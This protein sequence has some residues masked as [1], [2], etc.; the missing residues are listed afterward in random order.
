MPIT[1]FKPGA[2]FGFV[3]DGV[4]NLEL[5][6][7]DYLPIL[8][9]T[10]E[11]QQQTL[12]PTLIGEPSIWSGSFMDITV[13]DVPPAFGVGSTADFNFMVYQPSVGL[14]TIVVI[15]SQYTL[16]ASLAV[17]SISSDLGATWV[18]SDAVDYDGG[19]V[20][21]K[22]PDE[23]QILVSPDIK[24]LMTGAA[25]AVDN[26]SVQEAN[27]F[28]SLETGF[29]NQLVQMDMLTGLT[30]RLTLTGVPAGPASSF[31][32]SI[33]RVNNIYVLTRFVVATSDL[34]VYVNTGTLTGGTWVNTFT[35]TEG[36]YETFDNTGKVASDIQFID[37]TFYW[38][39][40]IT[41]G[42]EDFII[43][44][45]STDLTTWVTI[46]TTTGTVVADDDN[47]YP[48]ISQLLDGTLVLFT[49]FTNGPQIAISFSFDDSGFT[50]IGDQMGGSVDAPKNALNDPFGI[51]FIV[52]LN[53]LEGDF[54][55]LNQEFSALKN[56]IAISSPPTSEIPS[57]SPWRDKSDSQSFMFF[58]SVGGGG[59]PDLVLRLYTVPGDEVRSVEN[60]GNTHSL[61][62]TYLRGE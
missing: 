42:V 25:S 60:Y 44:R 43:L 61:A 33:H 36:Q 39:A 27:I 40:R 51:S 55:N 14:P 45:R 28:A 2:A 5:V 17:L 62:S 37:N 49:T 23:R 41:D 53:V 18:H 9:L 22:I 56:R 7:P 15:R 46:G 20:L 59:S 26:F 52:G 13:E 34:D 47:G 29:L 50:S 19:N 4:E 3:V 31:I 1:V 35:T 16:S 11:S 21:A 24:T 8:S 30:S 48:R 32:C 12:F 6:D 57:Q 54:V 58:K 38:A 10:T